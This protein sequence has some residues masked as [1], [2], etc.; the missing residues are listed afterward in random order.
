MTSSRKIESERQQSAR[1]H[2]HVELSWQLLCLLFYLSSYQHY[3]S[4]KQTKYFEVMSPLTPQ[5]IEKLSRADNREKGMHVMP[6]GAGAA[7]CHNFD[8][9]L[10]L[11]N[12]CMC[13]KDM[14]AF[15]RWE[16][17]D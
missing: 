16:V 1:V 14:D 6:E 17:L 8:Y 4:F 9:H 7:M 12:T 11:T 10:K 3:F 13:V 15:H 2:E 5:T